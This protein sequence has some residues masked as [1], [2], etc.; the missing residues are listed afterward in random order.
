MFVNWMSRELD[1]NVA[2]VGAARSGKKTAMDLYKQYAEPRGKV[3]WTDSAY[4]AIQRGVVFF[5]FVPP[6]PVIVEGKAVRFHLYTVKGSE[7]EDDA[8]AYRL[9]TADAIVFVA[10][11]QRSRQ[12]SNLE[13]MRSLE[14]DLAA[15]R[16]MVIL[17]NKRDCADVASVDEMNR[18]LNSRGVPFFESV[19]TEGRGVTEG[20]K[21]AVGHALRRYRESLGSLGSS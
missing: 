7:K 4:A 5:D 10:D 2:F 8:F 15:A 20:F 9:E 3:S 21:A 14:K 17:Y 16:S 11:S 19:A 6:K 1:L 13:A 12:E 18:A